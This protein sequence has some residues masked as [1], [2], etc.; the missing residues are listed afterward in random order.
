MMNP[1]G[2]LKPN[3]LGLFDAHGN[4]W[5]WCQDDYDGQDDVEVK[6]TQSR[7]LR[8]GT[9]TH[10]RTHDQHGDSSIFDA[11]NARSASRHRDVPANSSNTVVFRVARAYR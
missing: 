4:A 1:V 5:Q 2:S 9:L 7:V 10:T 11:R 6:N 8:G 3:G